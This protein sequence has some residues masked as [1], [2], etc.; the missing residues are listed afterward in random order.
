MAML[1]MAACTKTQDIN[2]DYAIP[3]GKGAYPVS[4]N[5]LLDMSNNKTLGADS[6]AGGYSFK[7]ELQYFSQDPVKEINLYSTVG[8]GARMP[9]STTPYAAA[10][11]NTKK[12]DTLLVSY[13]VASGLAKGTAIKLDYE[14]LNLNGLNLIRTVTVRS[15]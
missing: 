12:L 7:T 1:V 2:R 14:I 6:L 8:T 5:T 4:T 3:T 15:K 10:Y 11:S 13:T 9:V